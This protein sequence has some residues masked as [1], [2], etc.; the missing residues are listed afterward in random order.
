MYKKT[1]NKYD[2]LIYKV[3]VQ[4]ILLARLEVLISP[5]LFLSQE[6]SVFVPS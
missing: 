2:F 5:H 6:R 1:L 3:L 4:E